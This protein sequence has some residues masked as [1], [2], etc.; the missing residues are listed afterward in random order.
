MAS[1]YEVRAFCNPEVLGICFLG[2]KLAKE[3]IKKFVLKSE[4]DDY[5]VQYLDAS[6]C[7]MDSKQVYSSL[8]EFVK[9]NPLKEIERLNVLKDNF[10]K[11][12]VSLSFELKLKFK[13]IQ[14]YGQKK[15]VCCFEVGYKDLKRLT[16]ETKGFKN[17]GLT[18]KVQLNK[19]GGEDYFSNPCEIEL[20]RWQIIELNKKMHEFEIRLADIDRKISIA[21]DLA[22]REGEAENNL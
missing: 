17:L 8:E 12:K 5:Y 22:Y 21:E 19:F 15:D 1:I 16:E 11:S 6:K 2:E 20:N 4:R 10:L 13:N 9:K 3:Y 18:T 14:K 7:N